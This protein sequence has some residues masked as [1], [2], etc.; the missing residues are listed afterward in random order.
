MTLGEKD[1]QRYG[2]GDSEEAISRPPLITIIGFIAIISH[3]FCL[4]E[5]KPVIFNFTY[6]TIIIAE[7][8][9]LTSLNLNEPSKGLIL[10]NALD[11]SLRAHYNATGGGW[12]KSWR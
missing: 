9:W 3:V 6:N 5:Y 7:I 1:S 10:I 11:R 2:S 8:S 4:K 12:L